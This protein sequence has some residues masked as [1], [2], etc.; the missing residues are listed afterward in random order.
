M[1][2][3]S[4]FCMTAALFAL[5]TVTS[6]ASPYFS[7]KDGDG[8]KRF[9]VSAGPLYVKPTGKAQPVFVNTAVKKG[10]Q[11]QVG[12][13]SIKTVKESMS[14]DMDPNL[15]TFFIDFLDKLGKEKLPAE[16]SGNANIYG[17]DQWDNPGTG[18]EAD[19]VTTL[20][21]MTNY[22]FT[23]NVSL[24]I[25]AGIPPKV[26]LQGKGKIYAPLK[27]QAHPSIELPLIGGIGLPSIDLEKQIFI[28][29]L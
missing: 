24:E 12:D 19:D 11:A 27:A 29:D 3:K 18:L 8:F 17:L 23:D 21:I 4:L 7:L 14:K 5:P 2:K 20:G 15:S 28:T 16:L 26:D 22:F 13:V 9:S 25:K 10:E 6:A 1:M